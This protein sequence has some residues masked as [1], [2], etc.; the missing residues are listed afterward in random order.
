MPAHHQSGRQTKELAASTAAHL[1]CEGLSSEFMWPGEPAA[2]GSRDITS[3]IKL[4]HMGGSPL[5]LQR[6]AAVEHC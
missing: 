1:L 5:S 2:A 3:R 6:T 4:P